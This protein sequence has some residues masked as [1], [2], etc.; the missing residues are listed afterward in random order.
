LGCPLG[1][2]HPGEVLP[3]CSAYIKAPQD[4]LAHSFLSLPFFLLTWLPHLE[5]CQRVEGNLSFRT[6]SRYRISSMNPPSS[7][8][9]LDR[10]PDDVYTP[11]VCNSSEVPLLRHYV[12][13]PVLLHWCRGAVAPWRRDIMA[14][15]RHAH[16]VMVFIDYVTTRP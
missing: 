10:S 8:A 13:A 5:L 3:S 1:E 15:W 4:P 9:L 16:A 2:A 6:P 7:A 14:L 11:C 12:V